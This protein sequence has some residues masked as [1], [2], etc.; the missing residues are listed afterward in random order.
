MTDRSCSHKVPFASARKSL[1]SLLHGDGDGLVVT[2]VTYT[3][4]ITYH[5]SDT[6]LGTV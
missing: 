3:V 2:G 4:V 6:I 1:N 5:K